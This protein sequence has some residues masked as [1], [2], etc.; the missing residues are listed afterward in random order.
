LFGNGALDPLGEAVPIRGEDDRRGPVREIERIG[1]VDQQLARQ[2]VPGRSDGVDG[3]LT[4]RAVED[5]LAEG[6]GVREVTGAGAVA[7]R[8]GPLHRFL[9]GH[10]PGAHANLMAELDQ[11]GSDRGADHSRSEH[12]HLHLN[13]FVVVER[14]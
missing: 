13:P 10:L 11:P 8:L 12:T 5:H 3:A 9:A 4:R 1:D 6:G 7:G 14:S 2:P